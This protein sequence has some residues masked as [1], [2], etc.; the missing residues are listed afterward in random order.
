MFEEPAKPTRRRFLA[1]SATA[2]AMGFAISAAADDMAQAAD[3]PARAAAP[4]TPSGP[5]TSRS[6]K[7]RWSTCAVASAATQ[8]PERETVNDASQGV[9]FATMRELARYWETDYDW[10]KVRGEAERPAAV[11][12]RDRRAGHPLHP[13]PLQAS[14]CPADDRHARLAGLDHRAAEDH[15]SAD[16]SRRRYGGSAADAFDVVIPSL[17]GYGFSG[18]PTATGWDPDRIAR[19]WIVLMKRLGYTRFVAQG[20]DWGNAVT[21]LMALQ[22]AS[23]TARHSHQHAGHRSG[24]HRQG[25]RSTATRRQPVSRPTRQHA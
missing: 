22:S 17:P 8:W 10:R 18:K 16:R 6:P 21:E 12:D 9:Q 14:E 23:G 3:R 5:S 4:A 25:A 15:R 20:G 24:R 19:A 7:P 11:H 13:R 1:A 2:G